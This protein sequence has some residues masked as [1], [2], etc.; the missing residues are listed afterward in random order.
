MLR[1]WPVLLL[2]P[3]SVVGQRAQEAA[4]WGREGV[5]AMD[6]GDHKEAI[7]LLT[8]AWNARPGEYDYPFELGRAYVLSGKAVKAEKV[9]HPLQ[10]HERATPELY[11]LLATAYDSLKRPRAQEETYRYGIQR[12]AGSGELYHGL[13]AHYLKR[14]SVVSALAVCEAGL[15]NAPTFADNYHLA[16]RIMDA[17][18]DALWAWWY[19]EVFLN[20]TT[21]ASGRRDAAAMV[22][23]NALKVLKGQWRPDHFALDGAA[24]EAMAHC[25]D[26]GTD[27]IARQAALRSCF[28]THFKGTDAYAALLRKLQ[29]QGVMELYCAHHFGETDN[30]MFLK[31]LSA[32]SADF[33]RFRQWFFWNGLTLDAPFTRHTIIAP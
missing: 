19:G 22:A 31:W 18:G 28:I 25:T 2:L 8:K 13:A 12:F 11:Q 9:L 14:D 21:D 26:T 17:K 10:Y 29:E 30:G 24:K 33:E 6:R 15:R 16:A 27:M 20:L 3:L 5:V 23:A 7:R 1:W 4:Q 32:H